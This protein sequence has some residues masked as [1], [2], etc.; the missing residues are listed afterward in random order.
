MANSGRRGN[1]R[2]ATSS[3]S[4]G[5][6][7]SSARW[8]E[9][10]AHAIAHEVG[11]RMFGEDGLA[12]LAGD[13]SCDDQ[14]RVGPRIRSAQ[15]NRAGRSIKINIHLA[16]DETARYR[17]RRGP[18]VAWPR[19]RDLPHY[20]YGSCGLACVGLLV[21][22]SSAEETAQRF[23]LATGE[24]WAGQGTSTA[25]MEG[26]LKTGGCTALRALSQGETH[27]HC[28]EGGTAILMI[29]NPTHG[30]HAV[31]QVRDT[32]LDPD[33]FIGLGRLWV[34]GNED[35]EFSRSAAHRRCAHAGQSA[36]ANEALHAPSETRQRALPRETER[37]GHGITGVA[38]R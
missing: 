12:K 8:T 25:A 34:D 22:D 16:P 4:D 17:G 1:G 6:T 24:K 30:T 10:G 31:V 36:D 7:G 15:L 28:N 9:E 21:G 33:G 32:I 37:V 13:A 23:E 19:A 11:R 38:V 27:L 18:E 14:A 29:A 5:A 3:S 2:K 20:G 26:M 35:T